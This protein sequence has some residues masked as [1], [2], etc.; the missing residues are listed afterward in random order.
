M[1]APPPGFVREVLAC[2]ERGDPIER[3]GRDAPA[4][5]AAGCGRFLR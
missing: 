1:D 2:G 5:R 4:R 3:R